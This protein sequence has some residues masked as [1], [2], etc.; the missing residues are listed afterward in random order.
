MLEFSGTQATS[1]EDSAVFDL[2]LVLLETYLLKYGTE[3]HWATTYYIPHAV[4]EC[5]LICTEIMMNQSAQT[6]NS[7]TRLDQCETELF[8]LNNLKSS[9]TPTTQACNFDKYLL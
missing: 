3:E 8:N 9:N 7:P 1:P 2:S 5:S 6:P 4:C